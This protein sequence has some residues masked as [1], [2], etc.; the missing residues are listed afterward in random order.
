MR[1]AIGIISLLLAVLVPLAAQDAVAPENLPPT[2]AAPGAL[3]TPG[4]QPDLVAT[5]LRFRIASAT[6]YELRDLAAQYGL[7][8]EGSADELRARLYE[9][10]GFAPVAGPSGDVAMS[11][12]RASGAEFF[13]LE[14]GTKEIRLEGPLD[15]RFVDSAGTVHRISADY[16]VYNR[17]TK[18][19]QASG[20]VRYTRESAS[21]TDTYRGESIAIDLNDYSGVFVD[22]SFNMEPSS[23]GG[24]TLIVRFGTLISRSDDIFSLADGSLTACDAIDPHYLLRAK[25]VWLFSSGDWAV[26]NATLYIGKIP[27][28]W[29]P[30]F[31][32]PSK[33]SM[34]HPTAGFNS[35]A[36]GYLQTTTYILG[37]Q[38]GEVRKSS[39]LSV[40]QGALG[41]FGTYVARAQAPADQP[42]TAQ[43]AVLADLYSSLGIF[44]GVRGRNAASAPFS[45]NWLA[46][47]GI[48]RSVFL[49]STGFY[50]PFDAAGGYASVWN[51][52]SL[53]SIDLPV[54]IAGDLE[55]SSKTA[56]S[57]ISWKVSLPFYSDPFVE[58]DFLNRSESYDFFSI[59]GG[60]AASTVSERS[61]LAQRVSLSGSWRGGG[62]DAFSFSLSNLSAF[63]NWK[64]KYASSVGKDA[65]LFAVDPQRHFL[66][67]DVARPLDASF[68]VS[69]TVVKTEA[70]SLSWTDQSS[71][72]VE[73]R[74]YSLS[75]LT[76][77]D[78][79][80]KSWYWLLGARSA[81]NLSGTY[82][83]E[84]TG[85]SFQ[86][87]TGLVG[88]AQYRP[89]LYD[90][91]SA[92]AT[93][94]PFKV[95]DYGYSAASWSAG[96][97][98]TWNPF[99]K[100]D[101]FS[102]SRLQYNLAGKI[103]RVDYQG[104]SGSGVDTQPIY[105]LTWLSWDS[106][107]IL[108]HSVLAELAAKLGSTQERL[109]FKAALPPLLESYSFGASTSAGIGSLGATYV[110]SRA[111]SNSN[112]TS[113]SLSGSAVLK[114]AP[115]LR[116]SAS[117]SWD[118]DSQAPLSLSAEATFQSFSA[119]FVAQKAYGYT[120]KGSAWTLDG[121]QYFRPTTLT[122]AWKPTLRIVPKEQAPGPVAWYLEANGSLAFSQNFIQYTNASAGTTLSLSV[123]NSGGLSLSFALTS[124]NSS[125]WRY[126]TSLLPVSGDLDP[127]LYARDFFADLWDSLAIWDSV[128]LQR[129]LFKLQK[130]SLT[131]AVDAHDWILSGSVD[132]GPTLVT[133]SSGRPYYQ[134]N[135]AFNLAVT[136]K[137][138]AA[139]K[140]QTAYA[141]GAFVQ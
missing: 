64:S 137:D 104:L 140:S 58:Q 54:R 22:G 126:Y 73:D 95:A 135:V 94:H 114:P 77:Q 31:Y 74:F 11:I 101:V 133:P 49:E 1:R 102:P 121:T 27:V 45:L 80:F 127:S 81:A 13:T 134:M 98:A 41:S 36:G 12:E 28:L 88:Q 29:L 87:S 2:P 97:S 78:V 68:S 61:A 9:H 120:F 136:W 7:S 19:V 141:D 34:F 84:N 6:L 65:R 108:D 83:L 3:T 24:R 110:L 44:A 67:P 131:L 139:I 57:G 117:A 43:L 55:A 20:S 103:A 70:A 32:Y 37:Q 129:S 5:T 85:L 90:E 93:V 53:A 89:Y 15:I 47:A 18:E 39:A 128:G 33:A 132:A 111:D 82:A 123:K 8:S 23:A 125:V 99:A 76:P 92:P 71:A 106:T 100:S 4:S 138:I 96:T 105:A 79:D 35:R 115:N 51:A 30:F 21:R 48:S 130:L 26:A 16:V 52:W 38:G 119:R 59:L 40:N 75:W 124:L 109:S 25:K 118:F 17:D 63:L 113:S 116:L 60:P 86:A 46:A 42:D 14:N 107:M 10:F 56:V 72:Y 112:L 66:Y 62:P 91:R 69:Q 122:A 50:S